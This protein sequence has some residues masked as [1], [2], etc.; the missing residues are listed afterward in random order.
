[1]MMALVTR[2]QSGWSG[3]T[4]RALDAL[5]VPPR[6]VQRNSLLVAGAGFLFTVVLLAGLHV[7][8]VL[9]G[10]LAMASG[11]GLAYGV[12]PW[13]FRVLA[14]DYRKGVMASYPL[15]LVMLR[16]YLTL[17]RSVEETFQLLRP[18]VGPRAK[19][20][21]GRILGDIASGSLTGPDAF[22]ASRDRLDRMEWTTLMDTLAQNWGHRNNS[23]TLRPLTLLLEGQREQAALQ[24]TS[25]LDMVA[26]V[27]PILAIFGLLVGGLFIVGAGLLGSNG[28]VL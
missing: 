11:A 20:E 15:I 26:T 10:V 8:W 17:D 23:D 6:D 22:A 1:M 16:F 9:T 3:A 5:A 24:L 4:R 19:R 25:R 13:W 2:W 28:V 7:P 18:L 27:V 12:V 21:L 14:A